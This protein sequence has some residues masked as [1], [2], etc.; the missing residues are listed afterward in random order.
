[1]HVNPSSF[2]KA[3]AIVLGVSLAALACDKDPPK[4]PAPTTLKPG[5]PAG[6]AEGSKGPGSP[7]GTGTPAPGENKHYWGGSRMPQ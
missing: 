4:D 6:G 3:L 7:Q 1:M 5:A 2:V